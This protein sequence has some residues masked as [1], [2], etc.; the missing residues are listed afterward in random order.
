MNPY[1]FNITKEERENIL[2]KHKTVYNGYA[3]QNNTPNTQPLY[4]Q[5]FANDKDGITVN[6]KGEVKKYTN[7][8][9]NE[10]KR[11]QDTF[12]SK[13]ICNECGMYESVC[14]CGKGDMEEDLYKETGK[15]P[16]KQSFDYVEEELDEIG[17]HELKKGEKYR[18][19]S[20]SFEDDI[21]FGDEIDY[22]QGGSKHYAFKGDKGHSHLMGDKSI[23]QFLSHI[24][25]TEEMSDE[26]EF[27]TA[28]NK[29]R[30]GIGDVEDIDWDE[31]D[32]DLKEAFIEQK[33]KIN[34][35]FKKFSKYN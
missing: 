20:P 9:I 25:D 10:Q 28:P 21:E 12:E 32:E 5:D 27:E 16:K 29:I 31:V 35:M 22:P 14:E 4:T 6:N 30:R 18:Y 7:M 13:N 33:Q 15:F 19:K 8:G 23:E 3:V 26:N 2:D 24:D 11:Y 34:E 1:F 17:T